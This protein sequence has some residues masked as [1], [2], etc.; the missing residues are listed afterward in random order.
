MP[1][2]RPGPYDPELERL[3]EQA[4]KDWHIN[5][6][7]DGRKRSRYI[8]DEAEEASCDEVEDSAEEEEEIT[9]ATGSSSKAPPVVDDKVK[10]LLHRIGSDKNRQ[11]QKKKFRKAPMFH[12]TPCGL[13]F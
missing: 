3:F 9:P 12:C 1:L 10:K 8:E 7:G 5:R 11:Q 6:A 4:D 13:E 2:K